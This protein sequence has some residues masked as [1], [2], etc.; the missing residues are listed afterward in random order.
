LSPTDERCLEE[1][2][3][4]V[5]Q[6]RPEAA[7]LGR[8]AVGELTPAQHDELVTI[9]AEVVSECLD[10]EVLRR[11][12]TD[13]AM[14]NLSAQEL[15]A[16]SQVAPCLREVLTEAWLARYFADYTVDGG[17]PDDT[18]EGQQL[19]MSFRCGKDIMLD[20][21]RDSGM[22][23]SVVRC[24]AESDD[25]LVAE[26]E[27]TPERWRDLTSE[28]AT[29]ARGAGCTRALPALSPAGETA[30]GVSREEF[31]DAVTDEL[32]ALTSGGPSEQQAACMADAMIEGIGDAN[33]ARTNPTAVEIVHYLYA[34]YSGAELGFELSTVQAEAIADGLLACVGP[35]IAQLHVLNLGNV[36]DA[37]GRP[38]DPPDLREL[39][40]CAIDGIDPAILREFLVR[41]FIGGPATYQTAAGEALIE[42]S[43][44]VVAECA[45]ELGIPHSPPHE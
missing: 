28:A 16:G 36:H 24:Q 10:L 29:S 17:Q 41:Q 43:F 26:L 39:T 21:Y 14:Q 3:R 38:D 7:G 4:E 11:V 35:E 12:I 37:L 40:E 31:G 15:S 18:F 27:R 30:Y 1:G 22:P 5:E 45:D 9:V 42:N 34:G 6:A 20:Q 19:A 8:G 44:D 2:V 23:E 25:A 32:L 33:L 13:T